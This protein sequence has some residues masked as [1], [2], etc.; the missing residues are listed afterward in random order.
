M[1]LSNTTLFYFMVEVYLHLLPKVQLHV[2][3]FDNI[4]L[5]VVHESFE[6]RRVGDEVGICTLVPTSSPTSP[7]YTVHIESCITTFKGFMYNLKIDIIKSR[8]M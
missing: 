2:S 5:Q 7:L 8:N 6:S 4:H 3:G 1:F